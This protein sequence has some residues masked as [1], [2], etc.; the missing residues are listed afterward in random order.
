[1]LSTL[2]SCPSPSSKENDGQILMLERQGERGLY[3]TIMIQPL[4]FFG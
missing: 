3:T 2:S 1:M 4:P